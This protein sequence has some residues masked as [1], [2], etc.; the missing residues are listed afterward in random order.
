MSPQTYTIQFVNK[1]QESQ[2]AF[3][4]FFSRNDLAYTAGQYMK[5]TLDIPQ[6]DERGATHFFT[7]SS[8]PSEKEYLR[9]T[10]RIIQSTF[11]IALAQLATGTDVT[12][13]AP[14]GRFTFDPNSMTH[15]IFIAGGIGITPYRSMIKYAFDTHAPTPI[16][17]ITSFKTIEDSIFR[18]ELLTITHN[19]PHIKLIECLTHPTDPTHWDGHIGRIDAT[20]LTSIISDLSDTKFYV[21]GPEAMVTSLMETV[22]K[23]GAQ[24]T[25]IIREIFSGY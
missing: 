13:I 22:K 8:S 9:I 24:D 21:C 4:F 20:L 23:L 7:I 17:L 3:S 16:T 5:L 11:K 1:Q 12:M 18:E 10:T 14:L 6:P 19:S 15:H 25:Q 2:D